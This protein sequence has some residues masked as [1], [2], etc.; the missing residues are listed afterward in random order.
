M[1]IVTHG[2]NGHPV[3][4]EG[5]KNSRT[6][7][8]VAF[9]AGQWK[10][11]ATHSVSTCDVFLGNDV[12]SCFAFRHSAELPVVYS[13]NARASLEVIC[14]TG[15]SDP[16]FRQSRR[17]RQWVALCVPPGKKSSAPRERGNPERGER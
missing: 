17:A 12:Y 16:E 10:N 6:R 8:T 9:E 3:C 13:E 15:I 5:K 4:R 7:G 1:R 14:Y 11:T 2:D